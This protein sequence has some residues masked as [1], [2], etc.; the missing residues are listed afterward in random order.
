MPECSPGFAVNLMDV[1]GQVTSHLGLRSVSVILKRLGKIISR[2]LKWKEFYFRPPRSIN[3]I[4]EWN[5]VDTK[6][7]HS[8][9]LTAGNFLVLW[10]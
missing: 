5:F 1:L 7:S 10:P 8:I 2:P 3:I 9:C 6:S 4:Y